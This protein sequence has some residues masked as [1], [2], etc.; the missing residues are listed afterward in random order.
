[1]ADA[2]IHVID[3]EREFWEAHPLAL[4]PRKTI[5]RVRK[6]SVALLEREAWAGTGIPIVRDG[7][8][9]LYRKADVLAR[10]GL[11]ETPAQR[12]ETGHRKPRDHEDNHHAG[13]D[14]G[15]RHDDRSDDDDVDDP[16]LD[17]ARPA[18]REHRPRRPIQ[19][20]AASYL[21]KFRQVRGVV[22]S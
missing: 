1:V 11:T 5:A 13:D 10:L 4:F 12:E 17:A 14:A 18:L 8:R 15:G 16:V 19:P 2:G 21:R 7:T 9:C 6:C 20:E 22:E 3:D